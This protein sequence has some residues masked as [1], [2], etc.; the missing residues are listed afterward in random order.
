MKLEVDCTWNDKQN[1][2]KIKIHFDHRPKVIFNLPTK[3][4]NLLQKLTKNL[5]VDDSFVLENLKIIAKKYPKSLYA[6]VSYYKTLQ[7]FK[8]FK[9]ANRVLSKIKKLFPN[10]VFIKCII[11]ESLLENK[12]YEDFPFVFN[13]S[14]V[15]KGVFTR[16]NI[17]FFEEALF[18]HYVWGRYFFEIGNESQV[19]KHKKFIM[20]IMNTVKN[21]QIM[22]HGS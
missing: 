22:N 17:F 3:K 14:E 13:N 12:K 21:Y 6:Q 4:I 2:A 9:K 19:Q 8:Y 18:F 5:H 15:M 20:L 16:R 11:G 1:R 10:Q 7:F